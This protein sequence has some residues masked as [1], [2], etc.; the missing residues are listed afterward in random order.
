MIDQ[1][2]IPGF[3]GRHEPIAVR[4]F[5]QLFE[6]LPGVLLI[7]LVELLLHA[8]EFF[9]VDQ[10]LGRGPFH[11]RQRLMDHDPAV[12]QGASLALGPGRQEQRA[13]AGTL[14][15]AVGRHVA[16]DPLHRVVDRQPGGD[17]AARAVD[18]KMDIGLGVLMRQHQHLGH[19]QIGDRCH[20]SSSPE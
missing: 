6:R 15:D 14:A 8:D 12:R 3:F 1:T 20:R 7:D 16:R 11:P 5:L 10:D 9:R 19:D 2:I 17:A 4:I 13:H 18:V